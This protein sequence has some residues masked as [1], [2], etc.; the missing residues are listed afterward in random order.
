MALNLER[1]MV[2]VSAYRLSK[3]AVLDFWLTVASMV[4]ITMTQYALLL[5]PC[6][7]LRTLTMMVIEDKCCHTYD[8][9]SHP[10]SYGIDAGALTSTTENRV[11]DTDTI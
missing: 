1:Q 8:M 6:L 9:R 7:A 4:N 5:V 2:F 10:S 3:G 11:R